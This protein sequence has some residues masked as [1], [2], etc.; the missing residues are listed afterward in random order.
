MLLNIKIQQISA[1]RQTSQEKK[2]S[3][4]SQRQTKTSVS[5]KSENSQYT[6]FSVKTVELQ[7]DSG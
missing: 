7:H 4:S 3:I 2:T 5:Y 6:L 1:S